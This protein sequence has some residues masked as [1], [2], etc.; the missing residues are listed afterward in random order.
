MN[1]YKGHLTTFLLIEIT[2]IE[3]DSADLPFYF[4][5]FLLF[6]YQAT[7]CQAKLV[8][9]SEGIALEAEA[10]ACFQGLEIRA[11]VAVVLSG[12]GDVLAA[13]HARIAFHI[14]GLR[15]CE[16]EVLG[17]EEVLADVIATENTLIALA[18]L[19]D[20]VAGQLRLQIHA[21]VRVVVPNFFCIL[22]IH[23]II[24]FRE[25]PRSHTRAPPHNGEVRLAYGPTLDHFPR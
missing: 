21:Q 2:E 4:F 14:P 17:I 15:L 25:N 3:I 24:S 7:E 18:I 23:I 8:V 11:V 12:H 16:G 9:H 10:F 1:I 6:L 5:T 22:L 19:S 20:T 13:E